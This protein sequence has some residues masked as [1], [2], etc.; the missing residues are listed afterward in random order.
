MFRHTLLK[1]S[2]SMNIGELDDDIKKLNKTIAK[3][4]AFSLLLILMF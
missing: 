2:N 4:L 1:N 3:C